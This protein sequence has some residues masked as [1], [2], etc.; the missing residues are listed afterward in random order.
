MLVAGHGGTLLLA[1]RAVVNRGGVEG[2]SSEGGGGRGGWA[3]PMAGRQ[4]GVGRAPPQASPARPPRSLNN[5]ASG[6]TS[7]RSIM[8][9]AERTRTM[10]CS[11]SDS[12][13]AMLDRP[14]VGPPQARPTCGPACP[15]SSLSGRGA[16]LGGSAAPQARLQPAG[17][18][19]S[20]SL[21]GWH[22]SV[23]LAGWLAEGR[24]ERPPVPARLNT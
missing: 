11:A 23:W 8:R 19:A 1:Q 17:K 3:C 10:P 4:A 13:H 9:P 15:R 14:A 6:Q 21:A 5:G 22:W 16:S 24:E 2:V 18:V 7:T 20:V 12:H